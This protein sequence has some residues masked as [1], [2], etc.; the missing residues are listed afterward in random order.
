MPAHL[1]ADIGFID[2]DNSSEKLT[3]N[4][5]HGGTDAV[6]EIPSSLIS[7][8]K[9]SLH[10]ERRHTFLGFRHEVDREKPL[11]ERK[12]GIVKDCSAS[13]R[14]LVTAFVTVILIALQYSRNAVGLTART[15]NT[16]RPAKLSESSAAFL[17]VA[18]LLNQFGQIHFSFKGLGR[19]SF[20]SYA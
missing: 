17:I 11:R 1:S 15:R 4:L 12:V 14:K 19:F 13:C 5:S 20:H 10:L 16:F 2:F 6:A 9:R 7:N 3:V 18:K 8:V